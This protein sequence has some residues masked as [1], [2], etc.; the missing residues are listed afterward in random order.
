MRRFAALSLT[1]ASLL[2]GSIARADDLTEAQLAELPRYF[3]FDAMQIYKVNPGIGQLHVADL[4]GDGRSDLLLWNNA[5]SRFELFLQPDP[6]K[7]EK[8]TGG[9]APDRNDVPNRGSLRNETIPVS[10]RVASVEVA[11]V[12][13]DGVNDIIFFG[14]PRELVILPGKKGG[15]FGSPDSVRAP[16][17]APRQGCLAIGDF[18]HDGKA[19]V[20]LLGEDQ[21]LIYTQKPAGGLS[22]PQRIV[23][24]IKQTMLMLTTDLN[25]DGRDDLLIGVDDKE[26]GAFALLQEASGRLGAVRR[27]RVSEMRSLSVDRRAG[28]DDLFC[29]DSATGQLKHFRWEM[30][31]DAAGAEDWPQLLYSYPIRSKSKQRPIAVGD[32]DGDG[33]D[34]VVA[35]DPDA[36]QLILFRGGENGLESGVAFPGLAKTLDVQIGDADGDG[37]NEVISVS[38]EEKMVGISKLAD[39]RLS[40]PT[41]LKISGT[42]LAVTTGSLEAGKSGGVIAVL[43]L[44]TPASDDKAD[45]SNENAEKASDKGGDKKKD[46]EKDKP[47]DETLLRVIDCKSQAVVASWAV[48]KLDDDPRGLRFA[49]VDQDGRNDLLV[50][51]NFSPVR[52]YLQSEPGK[53][54]PLAGADARS[55]LV[56]E[57]ALEDFG[58]ADVTGDGKPEVIFAQKS[59]A[60]ALRVK[61]GRWE[62]IDQYNPE[63]ADAELRGFAA[64]PGAKAPTLVTYDRK[65]RELL[66]F[67]R[68]DDKAY[69]VVKNMP[70][71]GFELS[72]LSTLKL[73]KNARPALMLADPSRLALLFPGE[74]HPTLIEKGAYETKTKDGFLRDCVVGDLNHDGV[75]DVAALDTKKA[76]VE[77]LTTAPSGSLVRALVFQVFQGKRF[78]DAPD[79]LIDPR[80]ALIGDVTGDGKADLIVIAQDRLIVYPAQ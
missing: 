8:A 16:D 48:D 51:V 71:G 49:D 66:A 18:N 17:G 69:A 34:D 54:A 63:S 2:C 36:A 13:G 57:S 23:H 77:I 26:Y 60:R 78:S 1:F 39:G 75:R 28:G 3:G 65:S 20:A 5:K 7:P 41:P 40:F 10:Y 59:L 12:T 73:F 37:K 30:P 29:V 70:V 42:P 61:D 50:F 25:G 74:R 24:N 80:E 43:V 53:F 35:A 76:S 31:A 4:D 58:Y 14:E 21:L 22:A 6:S 68:R 19:D 56:K 11:D 27:I 38:R 47:K 52:A 32:V 15:G 9:T 45:K 64:I 79:S 55:G 44:D 62:V 33:R 72:A 67:E 46:K